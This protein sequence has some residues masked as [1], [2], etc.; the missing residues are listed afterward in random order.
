MR[1]YTRH[2]LKEDKFQ[3]AT[4]DTLTWASEHQKALLFGAVIVLVVIGSVVGAWFYIQ[5]QDNAASIDLGKAIRTYNAPL[6]PAGMPPDPNLESYAS[7]SE[8]SKAA[9]DAFKLV[10]EKYRHTRSADFATYY[11]GLTEIDLGDNAG[12]ER[13]LKSVADLHDAELSSL[14]KLALAGVYRSTNRNDEA[15]KIYKDLEEHPTDVVPK[16]RADLE[17]ASLYQKT[18]PAEATRL[19]QQI[20]KDDPQGAGGSIAQQQLQTM[21]K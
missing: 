4:A 21:K 18:N 6:R 3:E 1:R 13:D 14:A 2:Q 16:V 9:Q 5:K 11:V 8:R 17:L 19:Y 10:T 20:V 15:V 7:A 12:A